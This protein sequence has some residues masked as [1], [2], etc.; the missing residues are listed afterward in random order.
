MSGHSD[1]FMARRAAARSKVNKLDDIDQGKSRSSFFDAVY[2]RADGDGAAVPWADLAAKPQ[3]VEWLAK[4]PAKGNMRA[5]DVGCGL[6]DH[7][8]ALSKAGYQATGFDIARSAVDWAQKRFPDTRADFRQ[9]DLF[10]LPEDWPQSFDLVYECYT[11][12]SVP[13]ELHDDI[14]RKIASLVTP[15]GTLLTIARV[16]DEDEAASGPPWHLAPSEYRIFAELGFKLIS[17]Q[18]YKVERPNAAIPH[19]FAE[20]RRV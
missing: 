5:A 18:S 12:Q 10:N 15:G 4:N 16:R 8:Q 1:E 6:G 19:I 17:E 7:T 14:S 3:L 20:W 9:I 11:I 13:P 2:K